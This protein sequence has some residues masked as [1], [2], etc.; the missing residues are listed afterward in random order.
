MLT[1]RGRVLVLA[2][3]FLIFWGYSFVNYYL[4]I[5][6]VAML[7]MAAVSHPSFQASVSMEDVDI[8]RFIDKEKTFVDDFIHIKLSYQYAGK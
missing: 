6:G 2:G 7:F 1:N 4:A 3:I 5:L 8:Q